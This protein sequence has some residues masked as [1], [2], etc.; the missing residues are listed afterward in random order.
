MTLL[1]VPNVSEGRDR[2]TITAL[3]RAVAGVGATILDTHTDAV[4][5]RSV[6]TMTSDPNTLLEGVVELLAKARELIDLT[7][8]TG[9]HP[10]VGVVDVCPFVPFRATFAEAAE[11]AREAAG[12]MGAAGMPVFIYGLRGSPALPELR[13]GGLDGLIERVAAGLRPDH[14]PATIAPRSGVV[15]VGARGPLIAFNVNLAT[16]VDTA[17]S[18]AASI[19]SSAGGPEGLRAL[20]LPAP[21]GSQVSMNITEPERTGIDAIFEVVERAAAATSS[22]IVSTE[23]VGL[24]E[25]RFLPNPDAKAA[26]LLIE[27][28]RSVESALKS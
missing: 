20:G 24:V 11:V 28:G 4:H 6:F 1:A 10:R 8:H 16:D 17:R 15:C 12:R 21:S 19:R 23:I 22:D 25:E 18:I 2:D 7:K 13:R 3:Q 27:P 14:G 9:V 5:N 26:R